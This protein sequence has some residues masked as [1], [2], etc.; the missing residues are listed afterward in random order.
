MKKLLL[1]FKKKKVWIPTVIIVAGIVIKVLF[2]SGGVIQKTVAVER[3]P[4]TLEVSVTGRV[5][6]TKNLDLAFERSGRISSVFVKVGDVVSEGQALISL[7]H[8]DLDAQLAQAEANYES[9][10][11]RLDQVVRNAQGGG[12]KSD[13]DVS[14]AY[15]NALDV[16]RDAY[17]KSDDAVRNQTDGLFDSG[18]LN[19]SKVVIETSAAQAKI[20]AGTLS[21]ASKQL[22]TAWFSEQSQLVSDN[23]SGISATLDTNIQRMNT[24]LDLFKNL[25]DV[26]NNSTGL[27]AT[28]LSSYKTKLSAGKTELVTALSSLNKAKQNIVSQQTNS[29]SSLDDV[30][31]QKGLVAQAYA[32]IAYY[33]SQIAK[34][35]LTAP[36]AGTV[37]KIPY[38][39]GD[40][41]QPNTTVISLIGSGQYQMETNVTESD[42]S[43]IAVGQKARVTL[44]E[45]GQDVI[46][47]AHVI[48]VDLSETMIEG[49]P[50]YKT[51]LQFDT[52]DTRI[53]P[54]LTANID[55]LSDAKDGVLFIPTRAIVVRDAKKYVKYI[56]DAKTGQVQEKEIQTGLKG[57]DGRTEIIS[58]LSEGEKIISE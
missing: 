52:N 38:E 7:D 22:L 2:P 30:G 51:T 37:T 31:V 29:E 50:T 42:I 47:T 40:I 25:Q 43:K 6:P 35:R 19:D 49:V 26:L 27:D 9:Q 1:I 10:K 17:N 3:G 8:T 33:Q 16:I 15:S 34:A 53:L 57:S 11:A 23:Y 12:S 21:V 14:N 13:I 20:D 54:G 18:S 56:S 41:V 44:D 58:G 36:F 24:F 32:Q 5:K 48:A 28:T 4:V 55:I 46:F 39:K 45:Y